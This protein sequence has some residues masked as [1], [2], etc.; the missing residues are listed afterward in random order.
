MSILS[1]EEI[2]NEVLRKY[3][4]NPL[5]FRIYSGISPSKNLELL[6]TNPNESWLLK[7]DSLYSGKKGLG[8]RLNEKINIDI[9]VEQAGLRPIPG[10]IAKR[11]IA[12]SE[13][14]INFGKIIEEILKQEPKSF[15]EIKKKKPLGILQGP[16]LHSLNPLQS[17][18]GKQLELDKKLEYEIEKLKRSSTYYIK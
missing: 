16:I 11:L 5:G 18:I 17:L 4:K 12:M 8:V 2:W 1:E 9:K 6:I 3:N 10:Y 13:E 14:G 15:D 7:R